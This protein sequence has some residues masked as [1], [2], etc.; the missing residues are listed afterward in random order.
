[1]KL[2][3]KDKIISLLNTLHARRKE[4]ERVNDSSFFWISSARSAVFNPEQIGMDSY[5]YHVV[6]S[7]DCARAI[8]AQ[9]VKQACRDYMILLVRETENELKSLGI[10]IEE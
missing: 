4:L 3:D 1:M 6:D 2:S 5:G 9:L 10:T 7:A 8:L